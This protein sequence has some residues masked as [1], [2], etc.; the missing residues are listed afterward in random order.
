MNK[1]TDKWYNSVLAKGIA[2]AGVAI[3]VGFGLKTCWQSDVEL[4]RA[5][6][7]YMTQRQDLNDNGKPEEFVE[8]GGKRFFSVIDGKDLAKSLGYE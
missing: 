6:Q 1:M 3:A 8:V 7:G 2:V 4:E 5:K